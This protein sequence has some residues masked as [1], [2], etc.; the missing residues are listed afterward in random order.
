MPWPKID[1]D[2]VDQLT[3]RLSG[4]SEAVEKLCRSRHSRPENRG[5]SEAP[6][7]S[8]RFAQPTSTSASPRNQSQPEAPKLGKVPDQG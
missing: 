6:S 2:S 5:P 1:I 4:R 3:L 8:S 7:T